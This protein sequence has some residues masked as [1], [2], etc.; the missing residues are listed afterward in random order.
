M[1]RCSMPPYPLIRRHFRAL[2]DKKIR[3]VQRKALNQQPAK[4]NTGYNSINR[5]SDN[6]YLFRKNLRFSGLL[7][8]IGLGHRTGMPE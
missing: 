2:L 6:E 5:A 7:E 1:L 8:R 3:R 4:E